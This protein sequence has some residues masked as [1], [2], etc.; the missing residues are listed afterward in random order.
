MLVDNSIWVEHLRHGQLGSSR[1]FIAP[2]FSAILL[3]SVNWHV[4]P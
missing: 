4:V 3:L 1:F 2:K